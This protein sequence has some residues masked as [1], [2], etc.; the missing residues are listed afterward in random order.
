MFT[1]TRTGSIWLKTNRGWRGACSRLH[2]VARADV[3]LRDDAFVGRADLGV[4]QHGLGII[5]VGFGDFEL[6][7][8]RGFV[9]LGL[10]QAGS[11]GLESQLRLVDVFLIENPALAD[12]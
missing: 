5:A 7:F 3:P 2:K 8:G 9:R 1:K 11:S 6:R 12:S 10:H 4:L